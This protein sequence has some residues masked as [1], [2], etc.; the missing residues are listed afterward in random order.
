ML[1]QH[2][3]DSWWKETI[4]LYIAQFN[5]NRIIRELCNI[6]SIEA[7]GLA[8]ECLKE[9]QPGK[10]QAEVKS[11]VQQLRYQPLENYLKNGQW[12]EADIETE[13]VMLQTVGK[14]KNQFLYPEELENFPCDDLRTIDQLWVKY[15]EGRF[16]FSVQAKIY[17]DL[18]GTK[19]YNAEIWRAFGDRIGWRV[20]G[21]WMSYKNLT[22]TEQAPLGHLPALF[23]GLWIRRKEYM[24]GG[25]FS[26]LA[27]RLAECNT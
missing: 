8:Y 6:S 12:K 4:L 10:V 14:Q 24:G 18:G 13:R 21:K 20:E 16:G 1:L 26:S 27:W 5:P 22:F 2:W 7:V 17:R 19:E 9:S 3:Q 23:R 11:Q 25:V 15:S